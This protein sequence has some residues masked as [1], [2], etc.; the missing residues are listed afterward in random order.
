VNR[1]EPIGNLSDY[2][3]RAVIML[4]ENVGTRW[5]RPYGSH[6]SIQREQD[7]LRILEREGYVERKRNKRWPNASDPW[8]WRLTDKAREEFPCLCETCVSYQYWE[9]PPDHCE[10]SHRQYEV[11]LC[12]DRI[13]CARRE[14]PSV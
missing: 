6:F 1:T 5:F 8:L 9:R 13:E 14:V 3:R 12:L 10:M 11:G 2:Q 7:T 4:C